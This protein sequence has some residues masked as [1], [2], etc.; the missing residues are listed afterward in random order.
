MATV[1]NESL[2]TSTNG[3]APLS[4]GEEVLYDVNAS[5]IGASREVQ[6]MATEAR[7]SLVPLLD[8]AVRQFLNIGTDI[9]A[10]HLVNVSVDAATALSTFLDTSEEHLVDAM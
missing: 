3:N 4:R 10:T 9:Q 5:V 7:H 1:V 8:A 2:Y 6:L